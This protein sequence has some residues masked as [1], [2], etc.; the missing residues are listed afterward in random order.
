L[1]TAFNTQY[2]G[3]DEQFIYGLP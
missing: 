2:K 1:L 3:N